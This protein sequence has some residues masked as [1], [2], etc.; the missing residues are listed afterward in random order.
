MRINLV[1]LNDSQWE[2]IHTMK[3]KHVLVEVNLRDETDNVRRTGNLTGVPIGIMN[4][5]DSVFL[6]GEYC[7]LDGVDKYLANRIHEIN[8]K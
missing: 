4:I 1:P 6:S 2:I 8:W 5:I 3:I 7:F